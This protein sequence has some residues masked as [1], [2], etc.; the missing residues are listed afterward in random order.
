ML[1]HVDSALR[2]VCNTPDLSWKRNGM[3]KPLRGA[4]ILA[5]SLARLGCRRVF[6]MAEYKAAQQAI[7]GRERREICVALFQLREIGEQAVQ[8]PSRKSPTTS[9]SAMPLSR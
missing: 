3:T 7:R 4:E 8:G 5:Q 9:L 2:K 1:S 6:T